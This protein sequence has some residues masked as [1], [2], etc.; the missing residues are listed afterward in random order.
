MDVAPTTKEGK[1]STSTIKVSKSFYTSIGGAGVV[2][3]PLGEVV[4]MP[5]KPPHAIIKEGTSFN[6]EMQAPGALVALGGLG[7]LGYRLK[8]AAR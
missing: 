5:E 7:F 3:Q 1:A 6:R 8:R 4:Y 2:N